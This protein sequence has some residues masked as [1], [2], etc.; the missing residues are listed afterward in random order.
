MEKTSRYFRREAA[1]KARLVGTTTDADVKKSRFYQGKAGTFKHITVQDDGTI[2]IDPKAYADD[3][4][5]FV[6]AAIATNPTIGDEIK[7]TLVRFVDLMDARAV[8]R[9]GYLANHEEALL[10]W[11]E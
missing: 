7:Q 6:S 5:A 8:D 11:D 3:V 4:V 2:V 1:H 10:K 9:H